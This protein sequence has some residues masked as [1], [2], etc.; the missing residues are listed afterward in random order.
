MQCGLHLREVFLI[1]IECNR[2]YCVITDGVDNGGYPAPMYF[3]DACRGPGRIGMKVSDRCWWYGQWRTSRTHVLL[4]CMHP[5]LE[6]VRK[7]IWDRPDEEGRIPKRPTSIGQ[8][9]G[10]ATWEKPL[11]DWIVVSNSSHI[12]IS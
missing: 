2:S 7:E 5:N 8:L 10:K 1:L 4:R 3:Y 12:L 9:L 11:A 6:R